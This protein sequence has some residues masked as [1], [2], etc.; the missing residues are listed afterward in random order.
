MRLSERKR[1]VLTSLLV[2]LIFVGWPHV[3][4]QISKYQAQHYRYFPHGWEVW[5]LKAPNHILYDGDFTVRAWP[6]KDVIHLRTAEELA[7]FKLWLGERYR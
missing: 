1:I 3:Q 4:R 2:V 6:S 5:E 7:E